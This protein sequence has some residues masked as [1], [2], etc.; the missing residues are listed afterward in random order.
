MK[1]LS[2]LIM[3]CLSFFVTGL[4]SA[5]QRIALVIA[6]GAYQTSAGGALALVVWSRMFAD[7][8]KVRTV[9][10]RVLVVHLGR[11]PEETFTPHLPFKSPF[12]QV[13]MRLPRRRALDPGKGDPTF[14]HVFSSRL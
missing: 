8:E 10:W 5:E 6:N 14:A 11:R 12:R 3:L 13:G 2:C 9:C 4:A 1:K 7:A